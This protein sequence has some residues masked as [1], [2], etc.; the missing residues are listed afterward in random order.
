MDNIFQEIQRAS[1]RIEAH[2]L[3]TP[4]NRSAQ[5]SEKLS[6]DVYLKNEHL[7]HTGSFKLRGALNKIL[8]LNSIEK[9]KGIIAAST[10][11]HGLG[12]AYA[13]R[14]AGVSATVYVP[15]G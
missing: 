4:V 10:G 11:N 7:Q 13:A 6:L 15:E 8:S 1:S 14:I 9:K 2:I 12:V 5:L 3:K